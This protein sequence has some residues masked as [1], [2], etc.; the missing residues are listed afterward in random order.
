[1]ITMMSTV[2]RQTGLHFWYSILPTSAKAYID[3]KK[4]LLK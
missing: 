1:M 2:T 4:T 3:P